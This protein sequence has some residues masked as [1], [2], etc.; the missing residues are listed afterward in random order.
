MS[1]PIQESELHPN[2]HSRKGQVRSAV[3]VGSTSSGNE[4]R[5]VRATEDDTGGTSI[6][7][8]PIARYLL[9]GWQPS[10]LCQH[11]VKS[12]HVV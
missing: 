3:P 11:D 6:Q 5:V 12:L 10:R 1:R 9:V 8:S 2:E 7:H 4:L